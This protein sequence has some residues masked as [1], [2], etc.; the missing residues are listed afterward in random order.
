MGGIFG[1]GGGSQTI[2]KMEMPSWSAE[3]ASVYLQVSKN[4]SNL[5]YGGYKGWR[6]GYEITDDARY[7][8]GHRQDYYELNPITDQ[9]EIKTDRDPIGATYARMFND[10]REGISKLALRAIDGAKNM[11]SARNLLYDILTEARIGWD[12]MVDP[13]Y[14]SKLNFMIKTYNEITI[15]K[16]DQDAILGHYYGGS[17]HN[18]LIRQAAKAFSLEVAELIYEVYVAEYKKA[19]IEIPRVLP[20]VTHYAQEKVRDLEMLRQAGLYVREYKQAGYIDDYQAFV[21]AEEIDSNKINILGNA[22]KALVG[23][24]V[25]RTEPY[26]R[27]STFSQ[28]AGIGITGTAALMAMY[29][30]PDKSGGWLNGAG[31]FASTGSLAA[32]QVKSVPREIGLEG[33]PKLEVRI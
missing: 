17:G 2:E 32:D 26:Y 1:S 8:Q 21:E 23:A 10:E 3:A 12:V 29:S 11:G 15:P 25:S 18:L 24:Q 20:H 33:I 7:T 30:K 9:Y 16:I 5:N 13:L 31:S 27:P 14:E 6:Y 4:A 19:A 22:V 28:I